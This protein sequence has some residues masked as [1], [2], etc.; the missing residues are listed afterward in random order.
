MKVNSHRR[1]RPGEPQRRSASLLRVRDWRVPTKLAAVLVLPAVAFLVIAGVQINASV[2]DASKLDQFAQGV[3]VGRQLTN[4]IHYLQLERDRTAGVLAKS[5]TVPATSGST[6]SNQELSANYAATDAALAAFSKAARP[7]LTNPIFNQSQNRVSADFQDLYLVREGVKQ[8]WLREEAVFD[9]YSSTIQHLFD[10]VPDRPDIGGDSQS[11][12]E[13]SSLMDLA[14]AKEL[15]DQLRGRIFA[16]ASA[17][18]F[19]P[20]DFATFSEIQARH[21]AA[22]E[23]F[24]GSASPRHLAL[25][26][27]NL[28]QTA[29]GTVARLQQQV[30]SRAQGAAVGVTPEEWWL[31][32]TS[33]LD[34]IRTIEQELLEDAIEGAAN[35]SAAQRTD[36]ILATSAIVLVMLVALLLS[37][38]IG[39]SMARSLRQLRAQALDVAQH[40]LPEAIQRLRTLPRGET[41]TVDTTTRVRSTDEIGEVADAFTAVHR[42]A[43]SLAVEQAVMRRNVNS[44][45][46]N[47]ARR[48]QTLVERQLQLLDQLESAE[49]DPD[50]LANL[51]R[52]DH[53]ATRMRRND[54]NLLV[55][56]GSE[57]TR[58]WAQPVSL[59]AVTL[60]AMA[61][62]EQ[63]ARIRHDVATDVFVVGHAVS[64]IVHLLAE[65]LENATTFSPPDTVVTV[66]GWPSKQTKEATIVIEDRG[67]GMTESGLVDANDRVSAPIAI[68][69]AASERMG[70]VV[71]GHLAARHGVQVRLDASDEGV[72]AYVTLPARLLAAPPEGAGLYHGSG[73]RVAGMSR[74]PITAE[75]DARPGPAVISAED[76]PT[77]VLPAL[78]GRPGA[79]V[80]ED[81]PAV[82]APPLPSVPAATMTWPVASSAQAGSDAVAA[83]GNGFAGQDVSGDTQPP[84]PVPVPVPVPGMPVSGAPVT[85]VPVSGAPVSGGPVSGAPVSAVPVS[86]VPV[87]G[88][89][90]SGGPMR[91]VPVSGVP[92]A[93]GPGATNG[94]GTAVPGVAGASGGPGAAGAGVPGAA[95]AGVPVSGAP[96]SG[97][98]VSGAGVPVSG[99]PAGAPAAP[100]SG[101]PAQRSSNGGPA[102]TP[103]RRGPSRAEDIIGAAARGNAAPPAKGTR[104]WSKAGA[105]DAPASA[106]PAVPAQRTPVTAGTSASGLPIRVP[107]AQLPGD[108]GQGGVPEATQPIMVSSH[109]EPDPAS[110]SSMLTRFYSGVH[111]AANEDEVPTVPIN[112][113]RGST[114]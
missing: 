4:L 54:E 86:G 90:V 96:V 21:V 101:P 106:A 73:N 30:I 20:D 35:R 42:S 77:A 31:A 52:L 39:R 23:R 71:V 10:L 95:G 33:E 78:P 88:M 82:A 15:K 93:A 66:S 28:R 40:R 19:A 62:I 32:S 24:R 44:M 63:Y 70:L 34:Y 114:A 65:L 91:G 98:P 41:V 59:S 56:A 1:R 67:L 27:R 3:K 17:G 92:V 47:L 50:Q 72:T 94:A 76:A 12:D 48:S 6:S 68:D 79:P 80:E 61:E 60:A 100:A 105:G 36:A 109:T 89:P 29:V 84:V 55:L 9:Q 107:L 51:F 49:T 58:R 103:A 85:G 45:F 112:D 53:L 18:K 83:N 99:V 16:A 57:A 5:T 75:A 113:H 108:T 46:V 74:L 81:V 87:S 26:D 64:D 13:V 22:V 104:W 8:R 14:Q 111:R 2:Q 37:W 11:V 110:V 25:Y 38:L 43:V 69:V 97:V 102:G 7:L